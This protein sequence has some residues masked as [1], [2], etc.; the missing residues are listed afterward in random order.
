MAKY[1]N[2]FPKTLY[3]ANN[4]TSSLDT[5]TNVIARFGFESNLKENSSAFYTYSIQDSDTPEIIAYKYYKNPER[6][7]V[8]LLFNDIIDP[9]FDWPLKYDSFIK[10]VDTK[11]TANGA[12]N[13]TV[14]T[15]L[16]WAMS[17]NNVQAYYKIVKRTTTDTTPQGT[18]IEEKIELDANTY[19]NVATSSATYTLADGTTTV[20]T[21]TKEKQTYYD[22]EMEVNEAKRDI[23]LLKN[24]FV[25]IVEKEFKK[26]IKS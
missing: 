9:Q 2:Y 24:D 8:V 15:G 1:F 12:A 17:T 11:Y 14:Q 7:W 10:F 20:Q 13:T 3:S 6:H 4:K 18:T 21:I 19:A 26:V 5:V 22:Y 25:S 16:A 23:K